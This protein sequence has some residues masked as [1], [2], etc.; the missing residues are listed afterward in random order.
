MKK[1]ISSII[2]LMLIFLSVISIPQQT[3][4]LSSSEMKSKLD[5][6]RQGD[7][8]GDGKFYDR[9]YYGW[10]CYAFANE[11]ASQ[12]FGSS[13]YDNPWGWEDKGADLSD[14]CIGD[15]VTYR[16][17]TS[18]SGEHAFIVTNLK[19]DTIYI[20]ESNFLERNINHWEHRTM[21]KNDLYA[22]GILCV[23]HYKDSHVQTL[24]EKIEITPINLGDDFVAQIVPKDAT[25][26]AIECTGTTSGSNI[27]L[28]NRDENSNAQ[29][30]RFQRQSDGSY[31]IINIQT[32]LG[33]DI[34]GSGDANYENVQGWLGGQGGDK[35]SWFICDY[36]GGYRLVP[37][38]SK[39]RDKNL[40]I[41]TVIEAGRNIQLYNI[42]NDSNPNQ[43]FK[44]EF[45]TFKPQGEIQNLGSNFTARICAKEN[46]NLVATETG[47]TNGSQ[48]SMKNLD[49]NSEAQK[50]Y[51]ER[52]SNGS[53]KIKNLESNLYL[54]IYNS[55]N[56]NGEQVQIWSG[57]SGEKQSWYI[58]SYNGG[59]RLVPESSSTD[60]RAF[61]IIGNVKNG[62]NVQIYE[63]TNNTNNSQ[64][65]DIQKITEYTLG[66]IN[67]DGQV[68]SR[69][70]KLALQYYVG[71]TKL[72]ENQKLAGD[73]NKDGEINSRDA[74]LILQYYV[75][76]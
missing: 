4:A 58:Y 64:T 63:C 37:R 31:G 46:T 50:W 5:Q 66:D 49:E 16:E 56:I 19:G 6:L 70:A 1:V 75:G 53:Y 23:W 52:N 74:K 62:S 60:L 3:K 67:E 13:H 25:N 54:D 65:L 43:T 2:I 34:Y 69:D 47:K 39:N 7:I 61:D 59:Y 24:E 17:S 41:D 55:G 20:T 28:Q 32:G 12:I 21:S 10:T 68:N 33:M 8:W 36:N 57:G 18:P 38:S 42:Y 27:Y 9:Y 26:L 35:Q 48:I 15:V 11:L 14:L 30:W 40:D 72:T 22:K 29:K 76:K 73:V 51:F 44:I 71:K 45:N